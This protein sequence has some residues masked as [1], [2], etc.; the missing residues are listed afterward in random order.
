M[1]LKI[2]NYILN[3]YLDSVDGKLKFCMWFILGVR[4]IV[5]VNNVWDK[6]GYGREKVFE[7]LSIC[8]ICGEFM[9]YIGIVESGIR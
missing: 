2:R 9:C 6:R 5:L 7:N 1:L 8:Y 4:G 3:W